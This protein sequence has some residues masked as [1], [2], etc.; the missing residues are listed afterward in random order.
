MVSAEVV[1]VGKEFGGVAF[2]FCKASI[3]NELRIFSKGN[4][5]DFGG[6]FDGNN[7]EGSRCHGFHSTSE[8]RI[9]Q[10]EGRE[11]GKEAE[12]ASWTFN[13]LFASGRDPAYSIILEAGELCRIACQ[14]TN[15]KYVP[16]R[17]RA[18]R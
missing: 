17:N 11:V 15:R 7:I 13:F 8:K 5:A 2:I 4:R 14:Q 10:F 3:F 12:K 6:G 1:H 16:H 18:A 9:S